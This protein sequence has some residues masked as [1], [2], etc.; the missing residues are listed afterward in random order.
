MTTKVIRWFE[1][2]TDIPSAFHNTETPVVCLNYKD[3]DDREAGVEAWFLTHE[4]ISVVTLISEWNHGSL[5]TQLER[6]AQEMIDYAAS[7]TKYGFKDGNFYGIFWVHR[8]DRGYAVVYLGLAYASLTNELTP[9]QGMKELDD[10]GPRDTHWV[11]PQFVIPLKVEVRLPGEAP[12]VI[13]RVSR[14]KRPWVI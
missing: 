3:Y 14:Y 12:V 6:G 9:V 1:V 7:D 2:A 10:W 5:I 13:H 8:E 11:T 4:G